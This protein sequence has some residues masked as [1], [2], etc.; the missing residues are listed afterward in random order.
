MDTVGIKGHNLW[1]TY[2]MDEY[3]EM[4]FANLFLNDLFIMGD[5]LMR[6]GEGTA[7]GGPTS[8]QDAD[9]CLLADESTV[10]WGTT[11]PL[12]LKLARFRDNIMFL[13]PLEHCQ[14]WAHHLKRFLSNLYGVGLDFEQLG[15]SITFLETE[16]WC[17]GNRIEWG[18]KNKVLNG[19]LTDNP[20]VRRFPSCSDPMGPTL[21]RALAIASGKKAVTI[22]TSPRRVESN[23]SHIV[24]EF[25]LQGYPK[26][27]WS[28]HL[29]QIYR[30]VPGVREWSEV[31]R[32]QEWMVPVPAKHCVLDPAIQ[33]PV[34]PLTQ[35]RPDTRLSAV[36]DDLQTIALKQAV[37]EEV[38]A[39]PPEMHQPRAPAK[40]PAQHS[41]KM[42]RRLSAPR[43][44]P[45]A[46]RTRSHAPATRKP[47]VPVTTTP[48]RA[49]R[50]P[51]PR[52]MVKC[53]PQPRFS[54]RTRKHVTVTMG[55]TEIQ[56]SG[57]QMMQYMFDQP[58]E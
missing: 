14:Y 8:A 50:Q 33:Q 38:T 6:Q 54:N 40:T 19:R 4:T 31:M 48:T 46:Q 45:I 37:Q 5:T 42:P 32:L 7:I 47:H 57:A 15:R 10:P 39:I 35:L 25:T 26:V 12:S 24:W 1:N 29:R 28:S 44:Q 18:L 27:W 11:V 16:L 9:I 20:Q 30:Q 49:A 43:C 22:A 36:W 13:C 23:F 3:L 51:T 56:M 58:M 34:Y 55:N 21:V 53:T 52:A 41:R 17:Q 2:S